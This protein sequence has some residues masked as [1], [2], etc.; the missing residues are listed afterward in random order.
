VVDSGF[1]TTHPDLAAAINAPIS[2]NVVENMT[3][4]GEF[5]IQSDT[6]DGL[7]ILRIGGV[8]DAAGL[9]VP[10][11]TAHRFMINTSVSLG[12]HPGNAE[13]QGLKI[14]LTLDDNGR[15]V[16]SL[17][18]NI[19]RSLSGTPGTFQKINSTISTDTSYSDLNLEPFTTYFYQ[20][21]LVDGA[22]HATQWTPIFSATTGE[23]D[24]RVGGWDQYP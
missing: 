12:S 24:N 3:W 6:G 17:G 4:Q 13:S 20:V 2:F 7:N 10:D 21:F 9:Q 11:D 19:H 8:V 16:P 14:N 22:N 23:P 15:P 18:F 5:P 1:D